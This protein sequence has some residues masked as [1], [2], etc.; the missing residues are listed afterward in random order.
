M[1]FGVFF[2]DVDLEVIMMIY[3]WGVF[4]GK[5]YSDCVVV[6]WCEVDVFVG[7]L[8]WVVVVEG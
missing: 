1:E 8:W 4:N 6:L 7:N 3:G 5:M 2:G